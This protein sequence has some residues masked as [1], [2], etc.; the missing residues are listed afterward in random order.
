MV[1]GT[2]RTNDMDVVELCFLVE[3]FT[4]VAITKDFVMDLG[5]TNTGKGTELAMAVIGSWV[6]SKDGEPCITRTEL[7]IQVRG[8]R[9][10]VIF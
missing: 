7:S 1:V 5:S 3:M 10:L 4:S 6:E 2:I 8:K 9:R